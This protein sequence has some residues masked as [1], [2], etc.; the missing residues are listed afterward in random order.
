MKC[1]YL[2]CDLKVTALN[3]CMLSGYLN[4]LPQKL[5]ALIYSL[6]KESGVVSFRLLNSSPCYE[7]EGG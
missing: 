4:S 5:E 6:M 7:P 3:V 1:Q 2:L